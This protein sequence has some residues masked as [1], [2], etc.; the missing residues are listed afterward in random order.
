MN[1]KGLRS[2]VVYVTGDFAD[3]AAAV[4][5]PPSLADRFELHTYAD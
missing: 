5:S 2:A 3:V 1:E 4:A